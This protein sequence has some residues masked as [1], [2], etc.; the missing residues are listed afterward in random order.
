MGNWNWEQLGDNIYRSVQDA[1]DSHD[2]SSLNQTIRNTIDDVGQE[3]RDAGSAF[4]YGQGSRQGG[5]QASP[6]GQPYS[7]RYSQQRRKQRAYQEQWY[8]RKQQETGGHSTAGGRT[9]NLNY[10]ATPVKSELYAG[11]SGTQAV[12]I[13][14]G[15]MGVVLGGVS[16]I[17]LIVSLVGGVMFWGGVGNKIVSAVFLVLLGLGTGL[18]VFGFRK[19]GKVRRFRRYLQILGR[20]EYCD[21]KELA[22]R[23]GKN[24]AYIKKDLIGMIARGWF[25]QGCLDEKKTCLITSKEAYDQYRQLMNQQKEREEEE[26]REKEKYSPELREIIRR[27][28][29]YVAKIRTCNDAIPG[30][31]ISAKISRMELLVDRIFDRVEQHPES[32][33]DI[34]RLMDYYLPTTMKLLE[35][36]EE[37]D[38]QP[39]QGENILSSK[40]EIEKTL[41]TLNQAF[42]RL[43]DD[44]FQD[45]A[46][47]VSSDISVLNSMLAQEGLKEKDFEQK[48]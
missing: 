38:T 47:D 2:F 43:L 34:R 40:R 32:V 5:R 44:M 33:S 1:V 21:L 37:L 16:L 11:T 25:R 41:D 7:D 24:I 9:E 46:W 28:D 27:G 36:Y 35:A 8:Q 45:T 12:S 6:F 20:R 22:D 23:T 39:V 10:A 29:E 42:E 14:A 17:G 15:C 13:L 26:R 3:I 31:E 4:G 18:G 19:S 48:Q 30:E